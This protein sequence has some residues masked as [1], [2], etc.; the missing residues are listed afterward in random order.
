MLGRVA[1]LL[2][3]KAGNMKTEYQIERQATTLRME[4]VTRY[5]ARKVSRAEYDSRIRRIEVAYE[6]TRQRHTRLYYGDD[7]GR[8][9]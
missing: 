7:D 6:R 1:P 3:Y 8:P 5:L 9:E 2:L 4:M